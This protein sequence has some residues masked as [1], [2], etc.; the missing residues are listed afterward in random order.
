MKIIIT[1]T[2]E[3]VKAEKENY[4]DFI[5]AIDVCPYC[6][7]RGLGSGLIR[8]IRHQYSRRELF[9]KF[10]NGGPIISTCSKCGTKWDVSKC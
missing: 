7:H 1:K 8:L 5:K 4:R 3:E 10:Q 9:E 2:V 6:M